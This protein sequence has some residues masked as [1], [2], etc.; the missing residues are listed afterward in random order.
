[1][2]VLSRKQEETVIVDLR[3]LFRKLQAGELSWDKVSPL[4]SMK[5]V[6]Q[7]GDKIRLGFEADPEILIFREEVFNAREREMPR[8]QAA[9]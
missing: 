3:A 2:L 7:L 5:V 1:M 9:R 6:A 8:E 4:L